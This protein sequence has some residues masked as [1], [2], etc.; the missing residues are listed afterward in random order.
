L[1]TAAKLNLA[2]VQPLLGE[3]QRRE[4]LFAERNGLLTSDDVSST[5]LF[6]KIQGQV[7]SENPNLGGTQFD[8]PS[9]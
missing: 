3:A 8:L 2:I 7:E 1:L 6:D 4:G 9:L 5:F